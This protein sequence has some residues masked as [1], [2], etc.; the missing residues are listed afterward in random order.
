MES[1]F[2]GRSQGSWQDSRVV[3]RALRQE[4]LAPAIDC[5]TCLWVLPPIYVASAILKGF[6]PP[7]QT[8]L[9]DEMPWFLPALVIGLFAWIWM[10]SIEKYAD[11]KGTPVWKYVVLAVRWLPPI[12]LAVAVL[13]RFKAIY[14]RDTSHLEVTKHLGSGSFAS[15]DLKLMFTGDGGIEIVM[16]I[17]FLFAVLSEHLPSIS[18]TRLD[19]RQKFRN[20]L[21]MFTASFALASTTL[22]FPEQAYSEPAAFPTG[23]IGPV[24]EWMSFAPAVLIGGILM[25][26]G[27]LFAATTLFLAGPN[28]QKLAGRARLKVLL[29]SVSALFYLTTVIDFETDWFGQLHEQSLVL[30]LV[31]SIHLGVCFA[32]V[33]QPAVR[34]DAE[35]NHGEGRSLSM[36][37]LAVVMALIVLLL[38]LLHVNQLTVFGN[39]LGPYTYGIWMSSV[40][41]SSMMLVQFMPALGFDAAPRPEIWWMKMTLL[42]APIIMSMFTP[43][44]VLLIP[45]IWVVLPLSS[46]ASWFIEKD[47]ISPS[48][49]FVLYPLLAAT[50]AASALP[51]GWD[52]PFLAALWI[53]WIPGAIAAIGLTLHVRTQ[54]KSTGK[55]L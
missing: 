24:P 39:G 55:N 37:V 28:F 3:Y 29:L 43:Y 26:G 46:V 25:F 33:L 48:R 52:T 7:V 32:I 19:L 23:P 50:L 22:F 18:S 11:K 5:A 27:E 41:I 53:G 31:L 44:A 40:A 38:T 20:R 1:I 30:P 36:M 13:F 9:G 47:V 16:L 4:G 42:Y 2:Q 10:S 21:M 34:S 6:I 51:F 54:A 12:Q 35:L 17:V 15:A 14:A 8:M 45:A 49:S